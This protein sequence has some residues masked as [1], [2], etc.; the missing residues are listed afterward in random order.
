M[1]ALVL[2]CLLPKLAQAFV[3]IGGPANINP[4]IAATLGTPAGA[5]LVAG[6]PGAA[7]A[8]G[9]NFVD[10]LGQVVPIKQ[11]FRWNYPEITYAYDSTFVRY[12]GHNGMAAVSNAVRVLND[13]FEPEN[14]SYT[15]GVSSMDLIY[16]YD[17]LFRTWEFN[18]TAN[19]GNVTDMESMV[20]GL[21]VNH[22]GL[23]NPHRYCFVLQDV[24]GYI[25][26][27]TPG[28]PTGTFHIATRNYDPYT[29]QPT[30]E[31]NGVK[32][33]Y[34]LWHDGPIQAAPN[35]APVTWDAIEYAVGSDDEYSAIAGIRDVINFGGLFW[36]GPAPTVFRTPGV[37]F[38]PDNPNDDPLP[39]NVGPSRRDQPRH[40]LTFDDAGGF[41]Y[42]YRTNNI[43]VETLDTS[44]TLVTPANM[45]PP[46]QGST[47]PVPPN[48]PF[49]TPQRRT[50]SGVT[51]SGIT[52]T[53]PAGGTTRPQP[54]TIVGAMNSPAGGQS[55]LRGGIN[56]IQFIYTAYDSL[57][58]TQYSPH[59]TVWNDVFITNALPTDTVPASPPYFLQIVQRT[60]TV[61]DIIFAANDLGPAGNVIPV[62]SLPDTTGWTA[63]IGPNSQAGFIAGL[64]GPG[65]ILPPAQGTSIQY[66]FTT[67]APFYQ[68]IW[69]G[70]T[71]IEG[72]MI[73]Q[74]QWGWITN[75]GPA[76]FV[77]FPE[78]DIT[79]AEAITGPSGLV[80]E[81]TA[82]SV[83]NGLNQDY[84]AFPF[85][86]NRTLDTVFIYGRRTDTA[87]VIEVLDDQLGTTVLQSIDPRA[88]IMS[89]QLIK[90]PPGVFGRDAEGADRYIR[91]VNAIGEGP[92]TSLGNITPGI[93]LI[94]STQYDGLPLN[95]RKS[96]VI[97][98]SGFRTAP[99]PPTF[100]TGAV[101]D[102]IEFYDD[103]NA[104]F[105]DSNASTPILGALVD[106]GSWTVTD[107]QIIIPADF[108]SGG[109][110]VG[111]N[112]TAAAL[113]GDF[114][115]TANTVIRS[116][117]TNVDPTV[118]G[119]PRQIKIRR[120]D[121]L[122]SNPRPNAHKYSHIGVGGD[123]N[124]TGRTWPEIIR[125][126]TEGYSPPAPVTQQD[127]NR[128]WVRSDNA[129]VLI[130]RGYGLDLAF[131]IEFVDGV[132]NLI[133]STDANGLPPSPISLRNGVEPSALVLGFTVN[134]DPSLP[135]VGG[136]D[137]YVLRIAPLDF[138]MNA[139]PLFDSIAANNISATRRV[140][141]R[142]PFGTAIAPPSEWLW[143]TN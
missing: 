4:V 9:A 118:P 92:P 67:R 71:G 36:P 114:N 142:T 47:G 63:L 99:D 56:K 134:R 133:E 3:L 48:S 5:R 117:A 93:P 38:A 124:Q 40:T 80:P 64:N 45:N 50:I 60:S 112:A 103:A 75:T 105:Y 141:I 55:A 18:P 68:V 58:G 138:G 19:L 140:V 77:T 66:I 30:H 23:G 8:P 83:I 111:F 12:F 95:T 31:I 69:A 6:S 108:I 35:F 107:S 73:T 11:F 98:G 132:G 10:P 90:L 13:F 26:P 127:A 97:M 74:F 86:I 59:T 96:L 41:R 49:L 81:I 17:Q 126:E 84:K 102:T 32:H 20:L 44:V 29:Y 131:S 46:T 100:P 79:Q 21:L 72:N 115:S 43:V 87:T 139:N 22:L 88:Y 28:G 122:R 121:G 70:E 61:P 1:F 53:P 130:I 7:A 52:P 39:P 136:L 2:P 106:D 76:D 89:D 120:S 65:T 82:L 109:V 135:P 116:T 51:M 14:E 42:L 137:G 123:R 85:S 15:N 78:I 113:F 37:F 24:I 25:P 129:D 125:V 101:V 33:G 143:I 57:I 54:T 110:G 62:I 94:T 34:W 16:E 91:L 27:G 128:T 119:F 104:T